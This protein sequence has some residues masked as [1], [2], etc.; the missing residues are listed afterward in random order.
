MKARTYSAMMF[1]VAILFAMPKQANSADIELI[2][3]GLSV[4]WANMNIDASAPSRNG[5]YYAWGETTTK[6]IYSWATYTHCSGSAS[7]CQDIGSNISMNFIYDRAYNLS[8]KIC[9]PTAAQWEELITQCTWTAATVDGVK[10]YTVKGPSGKTIFLPFSGCSYDGSS[11]G[12]G[13]NAYYWSANNTADNASKAQVAFIKSGATATVTSINRRTGAA[14]RA[15]ET[16][17]EIGRQY[18]YNYRQDGDFNGWPII[19]VG[20]IT[21]SSIDTLGVEHDDVVVQE[22]L[23]SDGFYRIPLNAIDSLVFKVHPNNDIMTYHTCPD[24]GHPHIIDL[25]LPSGTK[26]ACCNVGANTPDGYGGYYAWGEMEE[27]EVYMPETYTY[28]D[29]TWYGFYDIGANICGTEYDVASVK[30]GEAWQMPSLDHIM[31]LINCCSCTMVT[32][33]GINGN[34]FVGPSG[35][36]IFI[37]F[38]GV[39]HGSD[40]E[41]CGGYGSYWSGTQYPY[42]K[43]NAYTLCHESGYAGY[44]HGLGRQGGNSVRPVW[45]ESKDKSDGDR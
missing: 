22:I 6:S 11:H 45:I 18:L 13:S 5:G 14:I 21:Y 7:S 41:Y 42:D 19:K 9:M 44:C 8:S 40:L 23:T 37:P 31:E 38:S 33:N 36:S 27:K 24:A 26:W 28:C 20:E 4:R 1:I 3:L 34:M 35:G 16:F 32:I 30:W 15:V 10:G 39:I 25:G 17:S 43:S 2:D 12:V 29:G